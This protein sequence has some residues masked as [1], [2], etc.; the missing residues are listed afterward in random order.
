[1]IV[2]DNNSW[3]DLSANGITDLGMAFEEL[4]SMLSRK[5]FLKSPSL[6]YAPVIFL[7]TDG[8]PTDNYK[9]GL[10]KLKNN[11]WYKYGMKIALG[12]GDYLM[13]VF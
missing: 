13:K 3:K 4:T 6:S 9:K 10:E 2:E 11:N 5:K 12:I 1:M 8:Y 7:M